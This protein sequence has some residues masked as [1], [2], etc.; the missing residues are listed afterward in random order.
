MSEDDAHGCRSSNSLVCE[1]YLSKSHSR[2]SL[3]S[4]PPDWVT[5]TACGYDEKT[6]TPNSTH[7]TT[8]VVDDGRAT[9]I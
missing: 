6:Q 3:G 4:V 9:K 8:Y 5:G 7:G 2:Q 1:T